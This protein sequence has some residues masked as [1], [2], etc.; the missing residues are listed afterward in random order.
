[1][2][3]AAALLAVP[4]LGGPGAGAASGCGGKRVTIPGTEGKD[5]LE[6]TKGPDVIE[7]G[8][9]ND[10]IRSLGG[11]DTI[12][13]GEGDDRMDGGD[14]NDRIFGEAGIDTGEGGP[15][16]DTIGGGDGFDTLVGGS[17]DDALEP[18]GGHDVVDGGPG[19]D[20]AVYS[21]EPAA[22]IVD[23]GKNSTIRAKGRDNL[24]SIENL[25]GS[26]FDDALYGDPAPN[27]L[28]G[29]RGRDRLVGRGGD[30]V[31]RQ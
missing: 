23:L 16:N 22:V 3:V 7:A 26:R 10:L 25:T 11:N 29:G 21:D 2:A 12:C 15:G 27:V 6:G 9:G 30:D 18:E 24:P 5:R 28:R 4:L 20:T 17:G 13:G 31:L 14:G 1:V 8:A 19:S